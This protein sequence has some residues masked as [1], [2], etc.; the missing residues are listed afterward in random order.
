MAAHRERQQRD[1]ATDG[2]LMSAGSA[3]RPSASSSAP[4]TTAPAGSAAR[5]W[6]TSRSKSARPPVRW[7]CP[8]WLAAAGDRPGRDAHRVRR[9][10]RRC[11]RSDDAGNTWRVTGSARPEHTLLGA[12]PPV[13]YAGDGRS[14]YVDGP[15]NLRL[16]HAGFRRKLADAPYR[17]E[18][19]AAGRGRQPAVA[20]PGRLRRAL[21]QHERRQHASS[22]SPIRCSALYDV[23]QLAPAGADWRTVWAGA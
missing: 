3:G 22:S 16:A 1:L 23:K 17:G 11:Y 13:L 9:H 8:A 5:M 15:G 4:T 7:C 21:A 14:C 12:Q 19:Q 10:G 20:L 6:T 18:P 2:R